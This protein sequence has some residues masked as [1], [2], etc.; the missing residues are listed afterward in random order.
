MTERLLSTR[1][2]LRFSVDGESH[3]DRLDEFGRGG[4]RVI[5]FLELAAKMP[6]SGA[7]NRT[8]GSPPDEG[9]SR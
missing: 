2:I 9:S 1:P 3:V 4:D 6:Y 8:T 7:A 5:S